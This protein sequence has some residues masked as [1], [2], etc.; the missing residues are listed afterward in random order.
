MLQDFSVENIIEE[1]EINKNLYSIIEKRLSV[2]YNICSTINNTGPPDITYI[3]RESSYKSIFKSSKL[4]KNGYY[5]YIYGLDT[6]NISYV[7]A[8][9]SEYILKMNN[10]KKTSNQNKK[11]IQ[12][13]F[14]AYDIFYEKDLRILIKFPGGLNKVFYIDSKSAEEAN[15][16][17]LKTV[18]LSSLMRSWSFNEFPIKNNTIFLEEINNS[19]TFEYLIECITYFIS[20]K[21][22]YKFPC[23]SK[24]FEIFLYWFFKY[25]KSTRHFSFIVGYFSKSI[26]S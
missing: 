19:N 15:S 16:E 9:I 5:H 26:L 3:I 25:L 22:D 20:E 4:N 7:A 21:N 23:F 12:T 14:C 13:I 24:K 6:S 2:N 10:I 1:E 8:Y 11:V 17:D 18:F